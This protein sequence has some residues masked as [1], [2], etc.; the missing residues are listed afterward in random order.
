MTV[1]DLIRDQDEMIAYSHRFILWPRLWQ[2][3]RNTHAWQMYR[4]C[5]EERSNIPEQSGIYTLLIQPSIAEHPACSYLMYVGKS[6]SLRRRFGNYLN[7]RT[8]ETGRPKLLRLLNKYPDYIWFCYTIVPEA[9]LD[10][11]ETALYTAYLPPS[12]DQYTAEISRIIGA[13]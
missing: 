4:L 9:E 3:Y 2:D 6:N 5:P 7:E 1:I 8:R 12:N 10:D 11:V 13:F